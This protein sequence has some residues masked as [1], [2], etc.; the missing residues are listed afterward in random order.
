MR[1]DYTARHQTVQGSLDGDPVA[2]HPPG[3]DTLD[4]VQSSLVFKKEEDDL[5][6]EGLL[7]QGGCD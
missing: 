4:R 5:M 2:T 1:T 6:T 7:L 3:G